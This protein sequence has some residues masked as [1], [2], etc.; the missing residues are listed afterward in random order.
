VIAGAVHEAGSKVAAAP[1][2]GDPGEGTRED[3]HEDAAAEAAAA[4]AVVAA[5]RIGEAGHVVGQIATV[6]QVVDVTDKPD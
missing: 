3:G 4:V 2:E 6:A 5:A 1:G